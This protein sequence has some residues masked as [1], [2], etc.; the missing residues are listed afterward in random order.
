MII[1]ASRSLQV[2]K[3]VANV[4]ASQHNSIRKE[5]FAKLVLVGQ[6][7]QQLTVRRVFQE[8]RRAW[9]YLSQAR[10]EDLGCLQISLKKCFESL[11]TFLFYSWVFGM[12]QTMCS[13]FFLFFF[14]DTKSIAGPKLHWA[15]EQQRQSVGHAVATKTWRWLLLNDIIRGWL[16]F[17]HLIVG[18]GCELEAGDLNHFAVCPEKACFGRL[19]EKLHLARNSTTSKKNG[20]LYSAGWDRAPAAKCL[21]AVFRPGNPAL[22][23]FR[24]NPFCRFAGQL[25]PERGTIFRIKARD[26]SSCWVGLGCIDDLIHQPKRTPLLIGHLGGQGAS[27]QACFPCGPADMFGLSRS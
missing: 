4:D 10:V 21:D 9:S 8:F 24:F 17:L 5:L 3:D 27:L 25:P 7:T 15:A 2:G 14:D 19:G 13:Q 16:T 18:R 23:L 6:K 11:L 22:G 20:H 1:Q 26:Q 12:F